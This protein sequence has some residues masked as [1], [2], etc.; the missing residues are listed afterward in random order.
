M[1]TTT[2]RDEWLL[3]SMTSLERPRYILLVFQTDIRNKFGSD[4]NTFD[5]CKIRNIKA[6]INGKC[7]PYVDMNIDMKKKRC[8]VLYTAY[9]S[10]QKSYYGVE[11]K[12]HLTFSDFI[13]QYPIY[14][15]DCSKQNETVKS[16]PVDVRHEVEAS[17]SFPAATTAFY[18][19]IHDRVVEYTPLMNMVR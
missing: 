18:V 12:P 10:F 2:T 3:Q 1:P 19:V 16:A 5:H 14:V 4:V 15:F 11:P 6:Y 8:A 17:E 7:F 13:N 9:T